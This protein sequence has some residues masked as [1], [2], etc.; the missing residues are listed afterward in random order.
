MK[1]PKLIIAPDILKEI[2]VLLVKHKLTTDGAGASILAHNE[3]EG[4]VLNGSYQVGPEEVFARLERAGANITDL[5][6]RYLE[7]RTKLDK[8]AER[9]AGLKKSAAAK[10]TKEEREALGIS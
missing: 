2:K 10:L 6:K 9:I 3:A 5:R 8:E 4:F 1:P 7:T